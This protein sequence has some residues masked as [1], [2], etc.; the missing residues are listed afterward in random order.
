MEGAPPPLAATSGLSTLGERK[1]VMTVSEWQQG[2]GMRASGLREKFPSMC[3]IFQWGEHLNLR[4]DSQQILRV[5]ILVR[6]CLSK[7]E[8]EWYENPGKYLNSPDDL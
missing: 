2:R 4:I 1:T 6:C 7:A 8:W 5:R 3:V